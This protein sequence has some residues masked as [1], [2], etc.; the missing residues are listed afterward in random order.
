LKVVQD[1]Q[2]SFASVK[3]REMFGINFREWF[4]TP[5]VIKIYFASITF[6]EL[7]ENF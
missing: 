7:R 6:C 3:V 2:S 5:I 1:G 4:M